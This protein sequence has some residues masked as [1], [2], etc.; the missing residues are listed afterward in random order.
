MYPVPAEA[1]AGRK[2]ACRPPPRSTQK[3]R[4]CARALPQ[5]L[6]CRRKRV[7]SRHHKVS[8]ASAARR[9][10]PDF[11]SSRLGMARTLP[12]T[13]AGQFNKHVFQ[14]RLAKGDRLNDRGKGFHH[15]AHKSMTMGN[16]DT[17]LAIDNDRLTAKTLAYLALQP[18]RVW[19]LYHHHVPTNTLLQFIRR[20]DSHEVALLQDPDTITVFGFLQD[21]GS[22]QD[23]HPFLV[24]QMLQ[25]GHKIEAGTRIEAR[26]RLIEQEYGWGVQER[27]GQLYASLPC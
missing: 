25:I 13:M 26:A 2:E 15:I 3:T 19:R 7:I 27:F 22:Q 20:P 17:H 12:K 10:A 18:H 24:T 21:M 5:R 1:S 6:R 14:G 11:F 8:T 23:T 9:R 4:G 16:L